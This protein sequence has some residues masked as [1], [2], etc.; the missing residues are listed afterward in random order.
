MLATI[1]RLVSRLQLPV[2][3]EALTAIAVAVAI[4]LF[5]LSA[6]LAFFVAKRLLLKII[7]AA[8]EKTTTEWDD[9]LV[10]HRVFYWVAHLAPGVVLYHFAPAVFG[11]LQALVTATRSGAQIYMIVVG[12]LAVDALVNAALD[13]YNTYPASK[14][15]PLKGFAQVIKIVIYFAAVLVVLATLLGK[16]P[17]VLLSGLGVFASV[18]MLVFKDAILGLVAGVQ[19]STNRMLSKGDW[20]EMPSFGADGDV[21][22]I[23]LT[24]VKVQNWDKTITTIPTYALITNSFKNWR[25]MSESGGRRIKRSLT[26]DMSTIKL[27]TDEML[28]RYSTIQYISEYIKQKQ[29]ELSQWNK[30]NGIDERSAANGRRLTNVGTF[31]AYMLAYLEHH[32]AIRK[33][34]TLL[35][36]QEAPS[37]EG[38]P[39]QIYCFTNTT[40]WA[41]YEE[42]QADI[43]DHFLAIA[44]EFDLR[45]FQN[46]SGHDLERLGCLTQQR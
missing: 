8:V 43:F 26:I 17:V 30:E 38:L 20:L 1:E 45:V 6:L 28:E 31:R 14:Q 23:A 3:P 2:G 12:L 34:M 9:A 25:G 29:A 4:L 16:S 39:I 27:C 33:D 44:G 37:T 19:L 21:I 46:P 5:L 41:L 7:T 22:D 10:T 36:R 11:E 18:M 42:I 15:V 13:I 35:V 24:T 32:S 40:E